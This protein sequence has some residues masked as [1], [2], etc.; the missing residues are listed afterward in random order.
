M[1]I[2]KFGELYHYIHKKITIENKLW[3]KAKTIL[4][5]ETIG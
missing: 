5:W 4:I 2:A 1:T 3:S